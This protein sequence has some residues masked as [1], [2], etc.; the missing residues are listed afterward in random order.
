MYAGAESSWNP[1]GTSL[2]AAWDGENWL[3]ANQS[4][5]GPV[6]AIEIINDTLFTVG[7][8]N[9]VGKVLAFDGI[10]WHNLSPVTS[11]NHAY[12]I[13]EYNGDFLV[14]TNYGLMK[15]SGFNNWDWY[16]GTPLGPVMALLVDSTNNFLYTGGAFHYV[17]DTIFSSCI[18]KYDGYKWY[19][20]EMGVWGDVFPG[21]VEMY[22]GDLYFGGVFNATRLDT[23]Y[24][25]YI[26]RWDGEHILP[27][28][29]GMNA[30]VLDLKVFQDTLLVAGNFKYVNVLNN[31]SIRV[32]GMA[33][34]YMP[35]GGCNFLQPV[36]HAWQEEGVSKDVFYLIDGEAEVNFYNNNAY[37]DSWEWNFGPTTSSEQNPA[38]TF[39]APGE[40][41][42]QLI[43]TQ[44]QCV[45]TVHK[46]ISIYLN[47]DAKKDYSEN[48]FEVFPNPAKDKV[49]IKCDV[50]LSIENANIVV[51]SSEGKQ[52]DVVSLSKGVHETDIDISAWKSDFV[53]IN[54]LFD[55][56]KVNSKKLIIEK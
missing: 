49:T 30:G 46:T 19:P 8:G 35:S 3:S 28:G 45:K 2:F 50:P 47:T 54:L 22:R 14:G 9:T 16:D 48:S 13:T 18:A 11:S 31:D 5:T 53:I 43:V 34:W 24:L 33:K 41:N 26:A 12:C 4:L 36:L 20:M 55:N 17:D 38:I 52:I 42:I 44:D 23:T 6:R 21:V 32:Q 25:N 51:L 1:N 29:G 7:D 27:V 37:A 15:R 39:T 10:Q 40:Y 56:K